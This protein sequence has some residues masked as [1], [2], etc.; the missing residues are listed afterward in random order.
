VLRDFVGQVQPQVSPTV[1]VTG[2][3][4]LCSCPSEFQVSSVSKARTASSCRG[5]ETV[6][7]LTQPCRGLVYAIE[8]DQGRVLGHAEPEAESGAHGGERLLVRGREDRPRKRMGG[9]EYLSQPPLCLQQ[10]N[11]TRCSLP[12]SRP[13]GGL[14]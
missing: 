7:S 3:T 11:G 6:V 8:A 4:T 2:S 14:V 1:T 9:A 10:L 5:T 13:S 12:R